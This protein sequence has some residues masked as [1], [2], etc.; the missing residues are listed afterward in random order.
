MDNAKSSDRRQW[1][2]RRGLGPETIER[3]LVALGRPLPERCPDPQSVSFPNEAFVP[4]WIE[5]AVEAD[6]LGS[7]AA[8]QHRVVELNF[9]IAPEIRST[10][11]YHRACLD[12]DVQ[13]GDWPRHP[14]EGG[15]AWAAPDRLRVFLH[16][17]GAGLIPVVE[18]PNRGD[19]LILLR[20]LGHRNEPVAIPDSMGANFLNGYVNRRRFIAVRD[21][22][23]AGRID[24]HPPDPALWKDRLLV[25]TEGP[26]SGVPGEAVG[27]SDAEWLARSRT[28]RLHHESCHYFV[29]RLFPHLV[30]GLQDELVADFAGLVAATGR[31]RARDFL[32][33]MGLE[34]F[35]RYRPGGRFENYQRPFRDHPDVVTAIQHLLVDAAHHLESASPQWPADD[36]RQGNLDVLATLT[37]LPLEALADPSTRLL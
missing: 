7:V 31:F 9:P 28:L 21:A 3:V 19:F 20:A 27:F 25:L 4:D 35:P 34:A 2:V 16:D 8:L 10:P 12:P 5:T 37:H 23:A 33:F 24:Q 15:P 30:F 13:L 14:V 36:H 11:D 18:A 1:L 32:V 29:R 6:R 22:H 17:T 26:Y